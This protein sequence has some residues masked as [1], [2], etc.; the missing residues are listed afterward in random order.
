MS[1]VLRSLRKPSSMKRTW[2]RP[3]PTSPYCASSRY[4]WANTPSPQLAFGNFSFFQT[5]RKNCF[6][7]TTYL[8]WLTLQAHMFS[9]MK[10]QQ[11]YVSPP[12]FLFQ[13]NKPAKH[14]P[15]QWRTSFHFFLDLENSNFWEHPTLLTPDLTNPNYCLLYSQYL[16]R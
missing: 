16:P 14:H 2:N 13:N 8:T 11:T 15:P 7:A 12:Y 9:S 4:T 6:F 3:R 5:V 10:N 1:G